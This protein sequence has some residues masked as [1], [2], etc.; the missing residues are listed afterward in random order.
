MCFWLDMFM[1]FIVLYPKSLCLFTVFGHKWK[2]RHFD[3]VGINLSITA[4]LDF[5]TYFAS[6]CFKSWI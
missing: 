1:K 4:R 5:V 6:L 3:I 2:T